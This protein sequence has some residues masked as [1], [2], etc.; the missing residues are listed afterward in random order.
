M[1]TPGAATKAQSAYLG[2]PP[3]KK[4]GPAVSL[5]PP[6]PHQIPAPGLP[7]PAARIETTSSVISEI[8][9]FAIPPVA[10]FTK[11]AVVNVTVLG[12]EIWRETIASPTA[13][14][15]I[16]ESGARSHTGAARP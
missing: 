16:A 13:F 9:V 11:T 14:F 6:G 8:P 12:A 2:T 7:N 1:G 10:Q 15:R 5:I 3:I 4:S